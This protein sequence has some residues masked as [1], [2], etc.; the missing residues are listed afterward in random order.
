[1][2]V[3]FER[4]PGMLESSIRA[5]RTIEPRQIPFLHRD[6]VLSTYIDFQ[7]MDPDTVFS[8]S[9]DVNADVPSRP[10]GAET[11]RSIIAKSFTNFESNWLYS[12]TIELAL[13]RTRPP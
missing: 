2:S 8:N 10:N 4:Q 5:T 13:S 3:L 12:A 9:L 1:M 11:I 7:L 6:I